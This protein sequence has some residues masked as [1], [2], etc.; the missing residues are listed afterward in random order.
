MA[1]KHGPALQKIYCVNSQLI[2]DEHLPLMCRWWRRRSGRRRMTCC[3]VG[4]GTSLDS[5]ADICDADHLDTHMQ[6]VEKE[7]RAQEHDML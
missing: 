6:V 2:D 7:K 5:P 3:R 4:E 1:G